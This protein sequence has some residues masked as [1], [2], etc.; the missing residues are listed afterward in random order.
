MRRNQELTKELLSLTDKLKA[1][2]PDDITD[3][4]LRSQLQT[5]QEEAREAK[6]RWRMMK[7]LISA[8]IAGSGVDWAHDDE[9]RELVLDDED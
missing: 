3:E 2:N 5:S 7:S 6:K 4:E 9:L 8:V 1:Q